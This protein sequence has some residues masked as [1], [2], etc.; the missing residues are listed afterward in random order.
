[1]TDCKGALQTLPCAGSLSSCPIELLLSLCSLYEVSCPAQETALFI[2]VIP[3][4]QAY[5][6]KPGVSA[7]LPGLA[8]PS[9]ALLSSPALQATKG[10]HTEDG[11]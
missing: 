1:M 10:T 6:T 11:Q 2:T 5:V 3:A 9:P 7:L 8:P 4:Q